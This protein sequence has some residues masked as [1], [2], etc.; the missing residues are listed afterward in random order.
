MSPLPKALYGTIGTLAVLFIAAQAWRPA[1]RID[2]APHEAAMPPQVREILQS[3]CYACHSDQPQLS[4]FDEIAPAR[5]LVA[6]DVREARED[7]NFSQLGLQPAQKQRAMLYDAINQAKLGTMPI[8]SY[9]MVHPHSEMTAAEMATV[10]AWLAPFAPAKKPT[11]PPPAAAATQA[12]SGPVAAEP[13]GVP[14]LP[15]Y[16]NW[17]VIST[18]DRGDNGTLRIITANDLAIQAIAKGA[19][20]PWPDGAVI[21]KIAYK[22][23]NDGAGNIH[24]GDFVQVELMEKDRAKYAST[25]GWGWGRWRGA[26]LKPYGKD[27][28]FAGECVG[29]HTPVTGNDYVFTMPIARPDAAQG[30][31]ATQRGAQ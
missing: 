17:R 20:T 30:D 7:L 12:A 13:N 11:P 16:R 1:L 31:A 27:A 24:A 28:H 23:A 21:A 4:W 6:H 9:R 8:A 26:D 3:R 5:W 2:R 19:L 18:T 14:F 29:C 25:A 22:A 10:E 15:D